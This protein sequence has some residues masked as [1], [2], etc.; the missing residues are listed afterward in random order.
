MNP[1]Y[2]EVQRL[3][4]DRWPET[5]LEPSLDRI[6]A[7]LDLLGNPQ[8][9]APVISL[10]GTN[11]KTS[12]SRM[13]DTLLRTLGL[14]TG[15]F[16]SP[17][18]QRINERICIDGVP[19]TDDEF[20]EAYADVAVYADLVDA[21]QPHRLSFFELIVAMAY[22]DFADAPVDAVVMEVGMGGTWDAT[23]VA[24]AQ[25]AVLTPIDVDH[26]KYLGDTP[27][28]IAVEKAGIIK[29][30]GH[31]VLGLQRPDVD[32]VIA[33]RAAQVGAPLLREG[34]DFGVEQR[35]AAVGGQQF[36]VAGLA[37]RYDDLLLPLHGEF[38]AHNAAVALAA[39]ETFTGGN[40]LDADLV[41][42]A[43]GETSSPGRVEVLRRSPTVIVDSAHNPHGMAAAVATVTS[44]FA[45]S[46]LIAV[47]SV[48]ADK[49]VDGLL[50]ELEP[51]AAHVVV[52]QNSADRAMAAAELAEAA[53]DRFGA[54]RVTV[55]PRLD[56]ALEQAITLAET[57]AGYED[58]VGSGGVLVTGSVVTAGEARTLLGGAAS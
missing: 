49:D 9:A 47:V 21:G 26:A 46:P 51:V 2:D 28:Q 4:L 8:D 5:K 53:V 48:M 52:T 29:A 39:V 6:T 41:R 34:V 17:H 40:A 42:Q 37:G 11:G 43:F 22:A 10:T 56:D 19:L 25:V 18:L 50:A 24:D 1:T 55:A 58:S 36:T 20:V 31:A 57:A 38:Q 30:G 12:T 13:I 14:R 32:E 27:A 33:R 7:V 54:D 35:V 44:E 15:R 45:L 3:L 23:N 16:T